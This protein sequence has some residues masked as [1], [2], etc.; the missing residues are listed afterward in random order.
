VFDG[1]DNRGNQIAAMTYAWHVN[2]ALGNGWWAWSDWRSLHITATPLAITVDGDPADWAAAKPVGTDPAGD[3]GGGPQG[4][5]VAAVFSYVDATDVYLLVTV[6]DPNLAPNATIELNLDY[7][8]GTASPGEAWRDL[9]TNIW[10]TGLN[11]WTGNMVPYAIEGEE[12][13]FGQAVEV[14]IPRSQLENTDYALPTLIKMWADGSG[15]DLSYL[16]GFGSISG[17]VYQEDGTTPIAGAEVWAS[18]PDEQYHYSNKTDSSGSY[19]I[20]GLPS[21][22]YRVY[23]LADGRAKEWYDQKQGPGSANLVPVTSPNTTNNIDFTLEPGGAISGRILDNTDQTE[24]GNI[25]I[26]AFYEESDAIGVCSRDDGSYRGWPLAPTK[27]R[28]TTTAIRAMSTSS[29]MTSTAGT[30]PTRLW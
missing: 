11:A 22:G 7:K 1:I 21:G 28:P 4:T 12:I 24:L 8:P 15:W 30:A 17:H 6:H 20:T 5:D 29:M 2:M 19:T 14:R 18:G 13:A 16:T 9:H 23:A 27:S 25:H 26:A 3:N 10:Q